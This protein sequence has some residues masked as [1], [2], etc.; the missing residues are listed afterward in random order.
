M[1]TNRACWHC[2]R[3]GHMQYNCPENQPGRGF[4]ELVQE[5]D[6]LIDDLNTTGRERDTL[7]HEL[8]IANA[9][10]R[11][12]NDEF[13]IKKRLYDEMKAKT[14]SLEKKVS[15]LTHDMQ[16]LRVSQSVCYFYFNPCI[17]VAI[18]ESANVVERNGKSRRSRKATLHVRRQLA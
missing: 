9:K 18:S 7:R 14:G 5:N 13:S 6:A 8:D 10:I 12:M 1:D 2:G 17:K 4:R 3:R 11:S 16:K 15:D